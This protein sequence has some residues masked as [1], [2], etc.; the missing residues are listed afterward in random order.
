MLLGKTPGKNHMRFPNQRKPKAKKGGELWMERGRATG[1]ELV[2][3]RQTMRDSLRWSR[4]VETTQQEDWSK[5]HL[6]LILFS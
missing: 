4:T 5:T 1:A 6:I 2:S 3:D